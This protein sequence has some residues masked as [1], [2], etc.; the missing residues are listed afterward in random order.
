MIGRKKEIEELNRLYNSS[1]SQLVAVYGRRRVGK[2]YLIDETFKGRITFRHAGLSPAQTGQNKKGL[3]KAQLENFYHSLLL[4]GM[5][6]GKCP[7]SWL[8]A[9]FMLEKHL[10]EIDDGTKQVVFLDELPW[11]DTMR[12]GF[13]TAF[14]SF[15]NNWA[16]HRDNIM[17]IVCGSANSW[18]LDKLIDSH[19]GLY[20]R[21]TYEIKL[22]PFTLSECKE[23]FSYNNIKLSDYDIAQS[24]M[25]LGGIPYY[26]GYFEQGQSLPQNIDRMFFAKNAKLKGEFDRLFDS[27]FSSPDA[28]KKIVKVLN[29]NKTGLSRD[30]ISRRTNISN[31]GTLTQYLKALQASDFIESY[32]PFGKKKRDE[33]YK[34][35]DPFCIFWLKFLNGNGSSGNEHFWQENSNSQS[36]TSWRGFAFEN[37][38][39]NHI[40]QIK[41][42]LNISGVTSK[43]SSW[44]KKDDDGEG[45]QVDLIIDRNDNIV[46]MCEIKFYSD[47]F[48]V[49]KSYYRTI[50]NRQAA[51]SEIIP[52]KK[53]VHNILISTYGLK[54]NEYSGIFAKSI[55]LEDLLL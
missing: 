46:D 44:F 8:E 23:Y 36:V 30:E 15:W 25:I 24:Y 7:K 11:M 10:Q 26:I 32:V 40:D 33:Q 43:Q 17:V 49:N 21:V 51:L 19:G 6:K 5:Q 28:V 48:V 20:N 50:M 2:T 42:A 22:E 13:L 12:S 52:K 55:S 37:L 29:T 3:I 47:D 16:C 45:T 31:G 1:K 54:Y 14:E 34:L 39:F 41:K 53:S 35:T 27:V 18:I 4:Q 38:C 9:F